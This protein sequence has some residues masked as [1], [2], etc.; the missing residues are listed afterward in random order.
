MN[1]SIA[2]PTTLHSNGFVLDDANHWS[3]GDML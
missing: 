1:V 2:E 3:L